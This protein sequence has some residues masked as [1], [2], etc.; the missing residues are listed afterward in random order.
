M[1]LAQKIGCSFVSFVLLFTVSIN[2]EESVSISAE[3]EQASLGVLRSDSPAADKA[4]ACKQLAINGSS[5]SIPD[6]A[7]LLSDPQLSSWARIALEAIPDPAADEALRT[8]AESLQGNLLIGTINSIGVRRDAG[9]IDVLNKRLQDPD[10]EVASAAA[11]ALGRV[12]NSAAAESL[13]NALASAS[14]GV[15]SAIAEGCVLC[16][17]RALVDG[18]SV[19]AI[20][21]YDQVRNA[22]V[23]KQRIIEATRGAIL[24]RNQD[25]IPL[26]VELFKS[27][28]KGLFQLALSTAREFPGDKVDESLAQELTSAQPDRAALIVQSMADRKQTVIVSAILKAAEQGPEPV[29]L[30]AINALA[31]VG[32]A[33]CL[34]ELLKIAI[35]TNAELAQAAK[36]SL[37]DLPGDT[38]DTQVLTLLES[39]KGPMVPVLLELVAK[40]RIDAVPALLKMLNDSDATLRGIALTAL[41]ETIQL[42]QLS[43][44]ID[45]AVAPKFAVDQASAQLALKA[46]S[47]R[48]PDREAC[49]AQLAAAFESDS[50]VE[51]KTSIL[52][53][54]AAVGGTNALNAVDAAGK[55]TNPKLQD[56]SS[57]LL[58][59]W[60]T[61]D[62]APVLL[63]LAKST[64]NQY[65][66][67]SIRAYIRIARQ[68]VLPDDRRFEMC[69]NAYDASK[70]PAEKKLVLEI[71]KRY[72]TMEGLNLAIKAIQVPELK[73]DAN[74]ATMIIAQKLSTKGVDVAGV[75][76]QAGLEKVKIEI[77][78]AEYGSEA[79]QTDVTELLQKLVSDLP[80]IALPSESYNTAFGGDPAAGTLK[81]LKIQYLFNNKPGEVSVP[82]NALII[83]PAPK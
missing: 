75:L 27:P 21:I 58:G 38:V 48:M 53:I 76:S 29:R 46:A 39:S 9:A 77:V 65:Q 42:D 72:P 60:M 66:V 6:L 32:D 68:F 57:R 17:E 33:S 78:K 34:P 47:V 70:L 18:N 49:A 40:R 35:E 45:Q 44:L 26:L 82:E 2:A 13:R 1:N 74:Q 30:S 5:E 64:K 15:R 28:D 24:A 4:I 69:Q 62:A 16:A 36:T 50:S 80:V 61:E 52:Q 71:L 14:E 73:T 67:R 23:P 31:R 63:E 8:A 54:L 10:G 83:L 41:G 3:K 79:V 43:V 7:K 55:S 11:V 12:G 37:A 51:N 22:N 19:V 25:G 81:T 20:E 56:I 59:E